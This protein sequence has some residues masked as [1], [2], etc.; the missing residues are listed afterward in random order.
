MTGHNDN[1]DVELVV[2]PGVAARRTSL[3]PKPDE[4][5]ARSVNAR[6]Y[7]SRRDTSMGIAHRG[8]PRVWWPRAAQA[9]SY[10]DICTE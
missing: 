3:L 2:F 8:V 6:P 10:C 7:H 1:L 9:K 5:L 4:V